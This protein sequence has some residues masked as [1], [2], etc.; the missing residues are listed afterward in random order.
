MTEQIAHLP[1]G[2][3]HAGR[4]I[5][6]IQRVGRDAAL[7]ETRLVTIGN[8]RLTPV[9][10]RVTPWRGSLLVACMPPARLHRPAGRP[11]AQA[12]SQPDPFS[13]GIRA[14]QPVP[15]AGDEGQAGPRWSACRDRR[16]G[17]ADTGRTPRLDDL[18]TAPETGVQHRHRDLPGLRWGGADHRLHRGPGSDR[19]DPHPPR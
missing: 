1:L 6:R 2:K 9:L 16:C 17:G 11:G 7:S 8:T 13:W 4:G 5:D 19:E 3:H 15:G 12:A 14:Q 18:G 10:R